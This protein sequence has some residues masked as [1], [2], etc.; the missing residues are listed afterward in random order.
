MPNLPN[1]GQCST[2]TR[3][4]CL[5]RLPQRGLELGTLS[6]VLLALAVALSGC[7][8]EDVSRE[9]SETEKVLEGLFQGGPRPD[10]SLAP[11]SKWEALRVEYDEDND[12]FILPQELPNRDFERFDRNGDGRVS[13]L[14]YPAESGEIQVWVHER[15]EARAASRVLWEALG[16]RLTREPAAW[17][18]RF[19]ELDSD[20]DLGLNRAELNAALAPR[21]AERR[22]G[23]SALLELTDANSND[24][25]DWLELEAL[26]ERASDGSR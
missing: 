9:A 3:E 22:D 25:L 10:V 16:I 5:L 26:I 14:D 2:A 24:Q 13:L 4:C 8:T 19:R 15:L 18:E 21:N 20:A 17:L 7:V 1:P 23:V 6:K 11:Q 12:G